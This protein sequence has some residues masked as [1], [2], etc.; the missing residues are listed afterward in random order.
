MPS[1]VARDASLSRMLFL[2]ANGFPTGSYAQFLRALSQYGEISAPAVIQTPLSTAPSRRW[3]HMADFARSQVREL[4]SRDGPITLVGHS[5]GGYL[6]LLAASSHPELVDKVIL[7]DSPMI[8]SWR[9][10]VF[11]LLRHLRLSHLVGPAPIA[12]RRRF[13]WQSLAQARE[14]LSQKS[15]ARHWATGVMDD[16][17]TAALLECHGGVTLRIA[18]EAERDIYANLPGQPA[19]RALRDLQ[20]LGMPVYM[21][22]GTRSIETDLAGRHGNKGLFGPLWRDID[23]AHLVPMETPEACARLIAE[24]VRGGDGDRQ[25]I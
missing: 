14:H 9:R 13:E 17:L 8:I 24:A 23:A 12:A 7:I 2:H 4:G 22:A 25:R 11:E 5:M 15:F 10:L 19:Y 3:P 20:S 18:R 16:F 21:I 1:V 6:S